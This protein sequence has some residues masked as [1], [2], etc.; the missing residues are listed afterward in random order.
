MNEGL[1]PLEEWTAE[2]LV[3]HEW[4]H[5]ELVRRFEMCARGRPVEV[6]FVEKTGRFQYDYEMRFDELANKFLAVFSEAAGC[7]EAAYC[8]VERWISMKACKIDLVPDDIPEDVVDFRHNT[9]FPLLH[10]NILLQM[11]D[12]EAALRKSPDAYHRW[13]RESE[14]HCSWP[15]QQTPT[16]VIAA[17]FM[18]FRRA[19]RAGLLDRGSSALLVR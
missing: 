12:V 4:T 5:D 8:R 19:L 11:A 2:E 7:F 16:V 10:Q 6:T 1:S 18:S 3:T 9:L 13:L 15:S 17:S 14:S